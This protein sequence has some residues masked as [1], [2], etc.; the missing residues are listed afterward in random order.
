MQYSF[1]LKI[2]RP[3]L[4]LSL[5]ADDFRDSAI[6]HSPRL[7]TI[8]VRIQGASKGAYEMFALPCNAEDEPKDTQDGE[9]FI[10]ESLLTPQDNAKKLYNP[11]VTLKVSSALGSLRRINVSLSLSAS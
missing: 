5:I 9:L 7:H 11:S 8:G 2:V 10:A 6:Y 1:R 4:F 3:L